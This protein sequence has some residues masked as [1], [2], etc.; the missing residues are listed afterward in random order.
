MAP[1]DWE[2]LMVVNT[3]ELDGEKGDEL[4]EQIA[5]VSETTIYY[6]WAIP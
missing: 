5:D 6:L 4:F 2:T 1:I 3:E